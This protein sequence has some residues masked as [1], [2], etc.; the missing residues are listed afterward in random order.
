MDR[1]VG[2]SP[3][4]CHARTHALVVDSRVIRIRCK[5][6]GCP[7]V[8]HAKAT[9]QIAIHCYDIVSRAEWTE[10]E[11]AQTRHKET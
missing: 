5:E 6:R 3:L 8:Q 4:R 10:F 1:G 2:V 7:D 11:P 9:G